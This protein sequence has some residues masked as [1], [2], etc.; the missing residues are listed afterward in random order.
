MIFK[1]FERHLWSPQSSFLVSDEAGFEELF[2]EMHSIIWL[3]SD[4]SSTELP[5]NSI[6]SSSF[7]WLPSDVF[8]DSE[9]SYDG[10][11]ISDFTS[12]YFV[13]VLF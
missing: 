8:S 1:T 12:S 5:P 7:E 3:T 6:S 11:L 10:D 13:A 4:E 2:E 9:V